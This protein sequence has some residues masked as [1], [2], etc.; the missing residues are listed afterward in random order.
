VSLGHAAWPER[1]I[2]SFLE[3][4]APDYLP[5]PQLRDCAR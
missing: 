1:E 5:L 4:S 3:A 2:M